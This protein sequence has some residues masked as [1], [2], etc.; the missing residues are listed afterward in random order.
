MRRFII[1]IIYFILLLFLL[2]IL[3]LFLP[4]TPRSRESLLF[5]SI[6]K[7][8][9]LQHTPQPRLIL[10]GGSNIGMGINSQII[11]DSLGLN[12]INTGYHASIG[13]KFM[14]DNLNSYIQDKDTIIIPEYSQ[15]EG[16]NG[17]G[18]GE[19]LRMVFDVSLSN[20]QKIGFRQWQNMIKEVPY[21]LSTKI[22]ITSYKNYKASIAPE[23]ARSAYNEYGDAVAHWEMPKPEIDRNSSMEKMDYQYN[24]IMMDYLFNFIEKTEKRGAVV[25]ISYPGM[26]DTYY[27]TKDMF[28]IE[29]KYKEKKFKILGTPNDFAIPYHM[30]Y[31]S[32]VHLTKEGANLRTIQLISKFKIKREEVD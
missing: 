22:R 1:D 10:V 30:I 8:S 24:P 5:S 3:I 25:Y 28:L 11:K 2:A 4:A 23:Y 7:D 16:N 27:Q 31:D 14:L 19:L 32:P 21:Y 12:P 15:F 9:L 13:L 6:Q 29:E 18:G 17:Y 26:L 20:I